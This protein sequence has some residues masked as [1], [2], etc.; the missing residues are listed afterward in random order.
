MRFLITLCLLALVSAGVI[1]TATTASLNARDDSPQ[2]RS[3]QLRD[4]A[5]IVMRD[6]ATQLNVIRSPEARELAKR[7]ATGRCPRPKRPV[8]NGVAPKPNGC[9]PAG[10]FEKFVPESYFHGCCR[11]HDICYSTCPKSR[12]RC[13]TEFLNCGKATCASRFP[14]KLSVGYLQCRAKIQVYHT[15][16]IKRMVASGTAI[17]A[18]LQRVSG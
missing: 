5:S 3:G 4:M 11:R 8:S 1:N 2:P 7:D 10:K 18:L 9:G 13:D 15:Q 17:H 16:P 6:M 12:A 14:R